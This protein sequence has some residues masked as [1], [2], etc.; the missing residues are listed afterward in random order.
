MELGSTVGPEASLV[1]FEDDGALEV[2]VRGNSTGVVLAEA[3]AID[4]GG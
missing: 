2:I 3:G 4:T 1:R